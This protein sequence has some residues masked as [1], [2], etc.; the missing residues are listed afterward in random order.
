MTEYSC[1]FIDNSL[2]LNR[3]NPNSYTSN[4]SFCNSVNPSNGLGRF[5]LFYDY[6]GEKDIDWKEALE[7]RACIQEEFAKGNFPKPCQGCYRIQKKTHLTH[8]KITIL[9]IAAWNICNSRCIYCES[10]YFKDYEKYINDYNSFNRKFIS[11]Y[12]VY[13]SVKNM[14]DNEVLSK[15][16]RIDISGGEP[17]LYPRFGELL[18]CLAE[19][20]CTNINILT[21]A[22]IYSPVIEQAIKL[23]S[24]SLV[25]SVDAGSREIHKKVKGVSSYDLVWENIE[26][27]QKVMTE[28]NNKNN[29][30]RHWIELKYIL[31]ENLNDS[32]KEIDKWLHLAKKANVKVLSM[33][34]RDQFDQD[35]NYDKK[36][37][38]KFIFLSKYAASKA[39]KMGFEMYFHSNLTDCYQKA[40]ETIPTC[41]DVMYYYRK[42]NNLS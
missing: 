5:A 37:L 38:K 17:T 20:G 2:A 25:I 41:F 8:K 33:N 3:T 22:I 36:F 27:Y 6:D 28:V 30:M 29:E 14:I 35:I 15:S 21:N 4:I 39:K 32:K 42:E 1:E 31:I 19:Y 26:K 18:A 10:D 7:K 16:A 23:N 9:Q 13:K 34:V 24:T 12:D 40:N 11:H